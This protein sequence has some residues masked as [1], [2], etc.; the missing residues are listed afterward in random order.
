MSQPDTDLLRN[1]LRSIAFK[2][3]KQFTQNEQLAGFTPP[4]S[5]S[6]A[7]RMPTWATE[8]RVACCQGERSYAPDRERVHGVVTNIAEFEAF[9]VKPGDRMY[10][11][12]GA[13]V[14]IW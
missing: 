12:E 6:W 4:Q 1:A 7:T 3:T 8:T 2:Q 14:K 11:A 5:F 9:G 10:R 13:R